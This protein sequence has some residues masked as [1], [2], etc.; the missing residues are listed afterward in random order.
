MLVD[1]KEGRE[2]EIDALCGQVVERAEQLGV[3][4]PLNSMLL[5]QIKSLR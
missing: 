1:V 3:E 2:T 5:A 4:S